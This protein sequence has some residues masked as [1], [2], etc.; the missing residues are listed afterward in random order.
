M[1]F[2]DRALAMKCLFSPGTCYQYRLEGPGRWAGAREAIFTQ[3]D[4]TYY[5]LSE[6]KHKGLESRRQNKLKISVLLCLVA[7]A[8]TAVYKLDV[9]GIIKTQFG[10][11]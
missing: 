10:I 7:V 6:G 5:T 9:A 2:T 4:R 1:I 11:N 3:W 8:V